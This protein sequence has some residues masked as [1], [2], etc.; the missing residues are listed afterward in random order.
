MA[1]SEK[2][3]EKSLSG[4]CAKISNHLANA[5]HIESALMVGKF[6]RKS[7]VIIDENDGKSWEM[8][9]KLQKMKKERKDL[10]K[11]LGC[12]KK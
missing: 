12:D 1:S 7:T 11:K 5:E 9:K 8:W 2:K 10:F 4:S 3:R 6:N